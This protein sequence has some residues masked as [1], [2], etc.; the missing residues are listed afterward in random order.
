LFAH[1]KLVVN[2]TAP[3]G[4][5]SPSGVLLDGRGTGVPGSDFVRI[6]GRSIL[7]R[8]HPPFHG[9]TRSDTP[10]SK[11][12]RAHSS[13]GEPRS[14]NFASA[15]GSERTHAAPVKAGPGRLAADAEHAVLGRLVSPLRS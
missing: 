10:H 15:A 4:L 14:H 2:G 7:A 1:Y 11:S 9:T 13:I 5:A 8:P 6:F 3:L 12:A